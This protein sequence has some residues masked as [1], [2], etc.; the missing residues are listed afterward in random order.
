MNDKFLSETLAFI[1]ARVPEVAKDPAFRVATNALE[2]AERVL[3]RDDSSLQWSK[4]GGGVT[5]D[6]QRQGK[7]LFER[8]VAKPPNQL[9]ST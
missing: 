1:Q 7:R 8:I 9:A 3:P 5:D 4:M 6:L 2:L